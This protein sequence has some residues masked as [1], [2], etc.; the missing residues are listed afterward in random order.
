MLALYTIKIHAI[1]SCTDGPNTGGRTLMY[2]E[3]YT[4]IKTP[5]T[6]IHSKVETGKTDRNAC[7]QR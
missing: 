1:T 2:L 3:C 4:G 5:F 6:S 7:S